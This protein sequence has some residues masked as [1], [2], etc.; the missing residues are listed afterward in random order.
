LLRRAEVVPKRETRKD[1]MTGQVSDAPKAGSG[2]VARQESAVVGDG[3]AEPGRPAEEWQAGLRRWLF[4]WWPI[5]VGIGGLLVL[6]YI[7]AAIFWLP[8]WIVSLNSPSGIPPQ[9]SPS[10][11]GVQPSPAGL[12]PGDRLKAI[13]DTRGTL[14]GVL[15]PLAAAIAGTA[16]WFGLR[17]T[18]AQLA[19]TR[20]QNE[21][22]FK[23][24]RDQLNLSLQDQVNERFSK[25]I[26]QLGSHQMDVRIGGIY[27]LEQIARDSPQTERSPGLHPPVMEILT[28]FVREHPPSLT[29]SEQLRIAELEERMSKAAHLIDRE[30]P[31]EMW[32]NVELTKFDELTLREL[33][34]KA[35]GLTVAADTQAALTVLGRRNSSKDLESLRLAGADLRGA[36]LINADLEKADLVMA[37]LQ[38]ASLTSANLGGAILDGADL[39]G[40]HLAWANLQG[41]SIKASN[42]EE[43][44]L[45]FAKL[46][47]AIFE[48]EDGHKS[49][50]NLTREQL[51]QAEGVDEDRLP[52]HLT[53]VPRNPVRSVGA[54]PDSS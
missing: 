10:A 50:R 15:I 25:A 19:E 40:A 36:N 5:L 3:D 6:A 46:Q 42:L 8:A 28:A 12:Q 48:R 13:S 51:N 9:P 2:G 22:T 54:E 43:A 7:V 37:N 38:G 23:T 18:Q 31:V 26:D 41:A 45:D 14:L 24:T 47:G 33:T 35:F 1:R 20:R 11:G 49:V 21:R 30:V 32:V 17:A 52:A 16:A 4:R 29:E 39:Q 44:C 53:A 34:T 27:A